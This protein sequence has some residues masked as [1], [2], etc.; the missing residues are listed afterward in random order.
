MFICEALIF[1][2]GRTWNIELYTNCHSHNEHLFASKSEK[3]H[4]NLFNSFASLSLFLT[5]IF[6]TLS[7][8]IQPILMSVYSDSPMCERVPEL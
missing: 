8:H 4:F 6:L 1:D 2:V 5:L 3:K 7:L